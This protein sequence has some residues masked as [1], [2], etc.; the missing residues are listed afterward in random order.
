MLIFMQAIFNL[1]PWN[2]KCAYFECCQPKS[3]TYSHTF[4][5]RILLK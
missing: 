4:R 3:E 5:V 1:G 2:V